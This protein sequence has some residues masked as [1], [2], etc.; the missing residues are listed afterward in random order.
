MAVRQTNK[1]LLPRIVVIAALLATVFLGAAQ[2]T[3]ADA[4]VLTFD[5]LSGQV[6]SFYAGGFTSGGNGPGP[7][8]GV[9]FSPNVRVGASSGTIF[10]LPQTPSCNPCFGIM[11]VS[12]GFIS[13]L[14]FLAASNTLGVPT[15]VVTIFDGVDGTGNI[16]V[17][18]PPIAAGN[19]LQL[20]TV[21]FNGVARSVTLGGI[22]GFAAYDNI[23]FTPAATANIPEPATVMLLASGLIGLA[24]RS[25]RIPKEFPRVR[26]RDGSDSRTGE[27][28][29]S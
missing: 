5:G 6:L 24:L 8:F 9:T 11:N 26:K 1:R 29:K 7:N 15:I 21:A 13:E 12:S 28:P 22:A 25:R 3:R 17:Q 20:F 2:K 23:T 16:L 10:F 19:S 18:T 27:R 4:I 14:S